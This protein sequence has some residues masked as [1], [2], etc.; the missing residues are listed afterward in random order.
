LWFQIEALISEIDP[1]APVLG[2]LSTSP[3]LPEYIFES[4][5]RDIFSKTT[6]NASYGNLL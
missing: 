5:P 3:Y 2:E 6:A 1:E 4:F